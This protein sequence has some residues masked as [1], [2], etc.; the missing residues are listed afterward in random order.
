M[1]LKN[2]FGE[3]IAASIII[4]FL[5]GFISL[6]LKKQYID[7]GLISIILFCL[8]L[9]VICIVC[10]LEIRSGKD[11]FNRISFLKEPSYIFALLIL[12]FGLSILYKITF[13]D[14]NDL[15][16]LLYQEY[17][18]VSDVISSSTSNSLGRGSK[19]RIKLRKYSAFYFTFKGSHITNKKSEEF[20]EKVK[21]GDFITIIISK[22]EYLKKI[23]KT[24]PLSFW[25]K[26]LH[27]DDI[28]IY[29]LSINSIKYLS[30]E[31]QQVKARNERYGFGFWFLLVF[32]IPI[33]VFGL[34]LNISLISPR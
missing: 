28:K 24:Q 8:V 25:D 2:I 11:I 18:Q 3:L 12:L 23:R 10:I 22:S 20:N 6:Q 32:S 26:Y 19:T 16:N 4:V 7:L 33:I 31:E 34:L 13:K 27:F 1:K 21:K 15:K 5:I 17:I 9:L 30:I 14:S 29:D